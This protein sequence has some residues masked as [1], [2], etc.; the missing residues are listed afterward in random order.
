MNC[1]TRQLDII[2]IPLIKSSKGTG[3][4][5]STIYGVDFSGA[6]QA[7]KNTWVARVAPNGRRAGEPPFHLVSLARLER[8]CGTSERE[9]ALAHLVWMIAGSE[10]ALWA[11]D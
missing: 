4:K 10:S 9:G 5:F 7:G 1:K 6:K 11:L 2:K 8:L 3:L